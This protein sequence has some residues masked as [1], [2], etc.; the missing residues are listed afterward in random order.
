[1]PRWLLKR[2]DDNKPKPDPKEAPPCTW[3]LDLKAQLPLQTW[4]KTAIP[5]DEPTEVPEIIRVIPLCPGI[6]EEISFP[7]NDVYPG[8]PQC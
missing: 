6:R 8:F 5:S 2:I 7:E 1:M 4:E 3:P